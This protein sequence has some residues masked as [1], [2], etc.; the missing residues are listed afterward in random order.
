MQVPQKPKYHSW[1]DLDE[2]TLQLEFCSYGEAIEDAEEAILIGMLS[3]E[4][5]VEARAKN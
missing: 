2:K 1:L 5:I 3:E 4:E